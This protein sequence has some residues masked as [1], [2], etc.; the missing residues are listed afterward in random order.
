MYLKSYH[1]INKKK[2]SA[3]FFF[4]YVLLELSVFSATPKPLSQNKL[5]CLASSGDTY[6]GTVLKFCMFHRG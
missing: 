3:R 1:G 6:A 4:F 2:K 5:Q